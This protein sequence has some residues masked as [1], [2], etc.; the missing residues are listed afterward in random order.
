MKS[1]KLKFVLAVSVL[2]AVVSASFGISAF[3]TSSNSLIKTVN[4]DL[5]ILAQQGA[6]VVEKALDE[7]W[8]ALELLAAEDR[9]ANPEIPM[10]QKLLDLKSETKR[11]GSFSIT[12]VDADGNTLSGDGKPVSIKERPYFQKAIKGERAVS[13][14]VVD[15]TDNTRVIIVYA[16]PIKWKDSIV[17]VIISARDG[18]DLSNITNSITFGSAG[19]SYMLNKDGTVVAHYDKTK[20]TAMD[21]VIKT[22]VKDPSLN[23]M[24]NAIKTMINGGTG[25]VSYTY[26]GLQ[27]YIGYAPV[28]N[29]DWSLAATA[30]KTEILSGLKDISTATI[31]I[32]IILLLFGIAV[33]YFLVGFITKP[34]IF[35]SELLKT[36]STGDFTSK[37]PSSMLKMKDELGLLTN[38]LDTMQDSIKKALNGVSLEAAKVS[39]SADME[40]KSM[41][42]LSEQIEEVS[43]TTEELSAGMEE[44]AASTQEMNATSHEIERAIEAIT[45]KAQEGYTTAEE[46]SKRAEV[47]KEN[48]SASQVNA[49]NIYRN[50]E[51]EMKKAIEQSKTVE[52]I[53]A[54]SDAILQISSQTNLLALNA[55]IE[56]ARAGEAGK[57]FS[58][59]AEE[60]RK[61]AEQSKS[62]V[63]EIQKVTGIVVSS[64]ENLSDNSS[65]VLDF[66]DKQVLTD[67]ESLVKTGEQ[68]SNDAN[69]INN[70]V[71]D[72][73]ATAQQLSAS[74]QNVIKAINEI[75]TATS[76]GA[77]GTSHIAENSMMVRN[78]AEIVLEHTKETKASVDKL[79]NIVA[80]FKV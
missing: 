14:P 61:L 79:T 73:S 1:I 60:I 16:V 48:A 63:A 28:E 70:I 27:E 59:V 3:I 53:D 40:E 66:I 62:T 78:K 45:E 64:V 20:V 36:I 26:N 80:R 44:T 25:M 32:A 2:L 75:T 47:L 35:I 31:I 9:I 50:T 74:I 29:T 38:S 22:A 65:K 67:Y 11:S 21:N 43:S 10:S 56:A 76:E 4:T 51:A 7:Q 68:Y 8:N 54:L 30:P 17:G 46:I 34:I 72:L 57:G 5:P 49:K 69:L 71:M 6:N 58:V 19:K 39:V 42:E 55:A 77:E 37:I 52:Q 15:K 13:D 23:K 12:V 18:N 41:T 24:A 33:S